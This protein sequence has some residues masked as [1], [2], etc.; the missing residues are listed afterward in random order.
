MAIKGTA[1]TATKEMAQKLVD[2]GFDV[3]ITETET[4][5]T[6]SALSKSQWYETTYIFTAGAYT[7]SGNRTRKCFSVCRSMTF[8]KT[9]RK[10]N[11]SYR[12]MNR[13]IDYAI[14]LQQMKVGA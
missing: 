9:Q 12:E 7:T 6:F 10:H 4:S 13:E 14:R 3:E 2:A 1:V 8:A 5:F 11:I